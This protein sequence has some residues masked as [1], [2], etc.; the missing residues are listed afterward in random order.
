MFFACRLQT[1][2]LGR[3][4]KASQSEGDT[5]N[6]DQGASTKETTSTNQPSDTSKSGQDTAQPAQPETTAAVAPSEQPHHPD[7]AQT[8]ENV[9]QGEGSADPAAQAAELLEMI[10]ALLPGSQGKE[11]W[12]DDDEEESVPG[13]APGTP[14]PNEATLTRDD[15]DKHEHATAT[16]TAGQEHPLK[17]PAPPAAARIPPMTASQPDLDKDKAQSAIPPKLWPPPMGGAL[18]EGGNVGAAAPSN[19]QGKTGVQSEKKE[20]KRRNRMVL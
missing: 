10:S 19:D 11:Y 16:S 8:I 2:S 15:T 4:S 1:A 17:S 3:N 9:D 14:A 13:T 12:Q 20:K 18:A 7:D 6:A 5:S